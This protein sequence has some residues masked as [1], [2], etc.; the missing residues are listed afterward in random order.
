MDP[1]LVS[2]AIMYKK[3]DDNPHLDFSSLKDK[4]GWYFEEINSYFPGFDRTS[5]YFRGPKSDK[6]RVYTEIKN[7]FEDMKNIGSILKYAVSTS[8]IEDE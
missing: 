8:V 2:F 1:I 4:T 3:S 7:F 5:V 6:D